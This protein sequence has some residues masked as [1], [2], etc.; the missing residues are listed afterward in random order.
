MTA[1]DSQ[2]CATD[3]Q[4]TKTEA[5]FSSLRECS[6]SRDCLVEFRDV[7]SAL[8]LILTM[9]FQLTRVSAHQFKNKDHY[10]TMDLL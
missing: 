5:V 6:F 1:S 10:G 2:T 7:T 9:M 8:A 4:M 3:H